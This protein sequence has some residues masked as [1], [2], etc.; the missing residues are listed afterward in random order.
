MKITKGVIAM[1]FLSLF[2]VT[3]LF[4][5]ELMT[6]VIYKDFD[7]AKNYYP[8]ALMLM[9]KINNMEVLL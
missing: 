1:F 4:A 2:L 6:S 3:N 9:K 5:G 7:A 8:Q